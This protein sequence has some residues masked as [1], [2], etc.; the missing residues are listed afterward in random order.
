MQREILKFQADVPVTVVLDKSPESAQQKENDRGV[1]YQ[2]AV[3]NN[4][5]LMFLP[6]EGRDALF[7]ARAKA[8]DLVQIVKTYRG[9]QQIFTAQTISD[10]A[11]PPAPSNL[12]GNYPHGSTT[13]GMSQAEARNAAFF[14]GRNGNG[15][16][17]AQPPI[18]PQAQPQR[19]VIAPAA[20]LASQH[21][22]SCMCAAIDAAAEAQEYARG[23]G[24]GLTFLGTDIRA[25]A[26]SIYIGDRRDDA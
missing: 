7:R 18:Q 26:I 11:E 3:N 17:S 12:R 6:P 1:Y 21:L 16:G 22:M 15:Q 25:I 4:S 24:L 23:K 10:A 20:M 13:Q 2:F 9:K 14:A 8:G 19:P 5:A